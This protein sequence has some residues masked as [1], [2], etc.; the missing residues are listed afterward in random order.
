VVQQTGILP[1]FKPEKKDYCLNKQGFYH[2]SF[3]GKKNISDSKNRKKI[4]GLNE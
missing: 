2:Y 4:S 3:E 1:L